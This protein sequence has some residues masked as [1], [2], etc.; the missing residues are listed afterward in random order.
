[1]Q[2]KKTVVECKFE[3]FD[4]ARESSNLKRTKRDHY[5]SKEISKDRE[6]SDDLLFRN[7]GR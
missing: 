3:V 1:M 4:A 7:E 2:L 5:E 6:L